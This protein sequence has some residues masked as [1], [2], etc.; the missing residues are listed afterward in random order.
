MT[1][2]NRIAAAALALFIITATPVATPLFAEE[3]AYL[4]YAVV[5]TGIYNPTGDLDSFDTG[6]NLEGAF[7]RYFGK[8]VA[9]EGGIGL[10]GTENDLQGTDAILGTYVEKDTISAV[11]L[12][13]T[14]KG[15]LPLD[16]LELFAGAGV[17]IYFT[18]VDAELN[19]SALGSFNVNDDDIVMG[20]HITGGGTYSFNARFFFGIDG[21]YF[22]T[23]EAEYDGVALGR[24]ITLKGDLTGYTINGFFGYR[25]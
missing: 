23:E 1:F 4:N 2:K 21:K 8:N 16:K 6:L 12:T 24:T 22:T 19:T 15:I 9:L 20:A 13:V 17:G 25:F 3:A 18:S 11:P 7:G 14:A 10:F 5:K